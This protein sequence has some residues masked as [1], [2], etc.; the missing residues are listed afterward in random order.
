LKRS[1]AAVIAMLAAT[2]SAMPRE[3]LDA[4]YVR[5]DSFAASAPLGTYASSDRSHVGIRRKS[6]QL[7]ELDISVNA[8][9][10]ATCALTGVARLRGEPGRESLAMP[11]RPDRPGTRAGAGAGAGALCQ[12]FVHLTAG[13]AIELRTTPNSCQAQSLCEG[14]VELDGQRFEPETRLPAGAAGPCFE[15]RAP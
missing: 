10:A 15:R 1:I 6:M 11:V 13:A 5:A 3:A 8:P 9:G 2:C 12:V 14:R 7:F 4:C